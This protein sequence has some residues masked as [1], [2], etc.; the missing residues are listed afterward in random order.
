MF[1]VCVAKPGDVTPAT[2]SA[3]TLLAHFGYGGAAGAIYAGAGK[4]LP[5]GPALRGL[6]FGLL[7]WTVSYLGLL[8]SL[9]VLKPATEHPVRRSALMIGAHFVWGWFL[10]TIFHV[11][12]ADLDRPSAAFASSGRAHR[13]ATPT[14]PVE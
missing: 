8:P 5:G 12:S 7:V 10:A 1:R 9:R 11:L 14:P 6:F 4:R 3:L 2:R 13:D